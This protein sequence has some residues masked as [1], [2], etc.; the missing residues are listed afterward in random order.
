MAA[1]L[2]AAIFER[3]GI[4]ISVNSAGVSASGSSPASKNA[5]LAM[6]F[7][8]IDLKTHKS[9]S[10]QFEILKN[11]ALVLTMTH[12]HLKHVKAICPGANAFTLGEFAGTLADVSDP[13]GGNLDEYRACAAQIKKLLEASLEKFRGL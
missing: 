6:E 13:F 9:Q 3:G 1:A 8:K 2:A 7:E 11:S 10:A 4:K 5:I 12:A